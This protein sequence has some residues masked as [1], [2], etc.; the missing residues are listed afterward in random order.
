M[1]RSAAHKARDNGDLNNA[2]VSPSDD[3]R[4]QTELVVAN[5]NDVEK[6]PEMAL[7]S[8]LSREQLITDQKNDPEQCQIASKAFGSDE[9]PD[10][11]TCY[12]YYNSDGILMRKWR[13]MT[14]PANEEW[15]IIHQIVV[16]R[17]HRKEILKLAHVS[18]MAGHLG[19]NKTYQKI[20]IIFIGHACVPT[21]GS[22][23]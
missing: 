8:P 22:G 17:V 1:T 11:G 15:Q 16:P 12:Y 21:V 20:C 2:V 14:A 3:C 13:P 6:I 23:V 5:E 19:I 18:P 10:V 7:N 9:V 4:S